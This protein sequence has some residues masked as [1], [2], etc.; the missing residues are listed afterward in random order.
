MPTRADSTTP[1]STRR[2]DAVVMFGLT[3]D[4]GH[5]KL[6]PAIYELERADALGVPVIGVGRSEHTDDELRTMFRESLAEHEP[7]DGSTVDESVIDRVDLRYLAGDSSDP[8]TFDLLLDALDEP[9]AP[10]IYAALPPD[11]FG[12][13][14]AGIAASRFPDRTRLMVE[15]PFGNDMQSARQLWDDITEHIPEDQLF[16]VD[17][18]LAKSAVENIAVVR[19]V[20]ALFANSLD[21]DHVD[22]LDIE[23]SETGSVDGRGSFYEGVGAIDDVVQ[24]H[25]LQTLALALMRAPDHESTDDYRRERAGLLADIEPVDV[26]TVVL[27]QYDGYRDHD[28]VADD[29]TV[30]TYASLRLSM[31]DDRWHGVPITLRTGKQLAQDSTSVTFHLAAPDNA[32]A[33][34]PNRVRFEIKPSAAVTLDIAVL[35]PSTHEPT[36]VTVEACGSH[37]HGGLGDYATMFDNAMN[38]DQWHFA[39]IDGIVEAWRILAPLRQAHLPLRSYQPGST[40]PTAHSPDLRRRHDTEE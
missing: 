33:S 4:L 1:P 35:D 21:R 34:L 24:S 3:G 15:K 7:A 2:S 17:H 25:M 23:M 19:H 8:D 30:E 16:I 29:S 27:G 28:G 10:L 12:G 9:V 26:S 37:D 39:H 40:G 36:S 5:K 11:L 14:A 13:V 20:N 22:A 31:S 6:F 32:T 38:G 18:F